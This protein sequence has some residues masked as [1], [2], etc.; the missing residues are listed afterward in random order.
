M[1]QALAIQL[2][3]WAIL[4]AALEAQF[5]T[6]TVLGTLTDPSG[7]VVAGRRWNFATR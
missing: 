1:R 4:P 7:A 5:E 2:L 6:S 3:L